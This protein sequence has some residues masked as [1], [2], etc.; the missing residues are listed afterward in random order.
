M[1]NPLGGCRLLGK[2]FWE[3]ENASTVL[4]ELLEDTNI[5]VIPSEVQ[6]RRAVWKVIFKTPN[7]DTEFLK[8]LKLFLEKEGQTVPGMFQALGMR[9]WLQPQ[10]P[11][12]PRSSWPM[13][14][15]RQSHTPL[16]SCSP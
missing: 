10:C 9:E 12:C 15:D 2:I 14:W 1:L 4:L 6:G 3:Q 11:M 16:S 5:S 8:R 7:Q 13:C